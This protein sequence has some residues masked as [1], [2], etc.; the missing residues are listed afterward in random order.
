MGLITIR[1]TLASNGGK[2]I[3]LLIHSLNGNP[4]PCAVV[5]DG[6]FQGFIGGTIYSLDEILQSELSK[7]PG[8][9]VKERT[10]IVAIAN[11]EPER[12]REDSP[13]TTSGE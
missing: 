5:K 12:S 2:D 7:H 9:T 4:S 13:A 3:D 8:Y 10:N 6:L 11:P 1:S